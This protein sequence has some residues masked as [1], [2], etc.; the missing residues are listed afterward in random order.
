MAIAAIQERARRWAAGDRSPDGRK[1]GLV[2]EGGGMRGVCSGGGA[3]A[4][5]HLGFTDLFDEVFATSAGVMNA[6]Y[7]LSGQGEL[8]ITVYYDCLANRS[9]MNAFRVWK[10]L[11]VDYVFNHVVTIAKPLDVARVL[12]S[13]SRFFV[14]LIDRANGEGILVDTKETR[15]SLLDVLKAATAIP[16]LYNRTVNVDGRA[17]MDGGLVIPFPLEHALANGCSDV[18]V[19]LSRPVTF[20]IG[21]PGWVGRKMFDLICARGN[22]GVRD[23]Y[24]HHHERSRVVRDLALGRVTMPGAVNIATICTDEPETVH[25]TTSDRALLRAAAVDYGRKTMRVFGA[26][27]ESW[28]LAPLTKIR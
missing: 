23:A 14:A 7:F 4:L 6:S 25:R 19:L 17:C 15:S 18:L 1:L 2:I 3:V 11:D 21:E 5:G 16:V 12:A 26:D 10:V 22:A 9:F 8:G 24:A 27:P 28:D 13:R 20:R